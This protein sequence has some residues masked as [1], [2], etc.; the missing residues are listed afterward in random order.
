MKAIVLTLSLAIGVTLAP[1]LSLEGAVATAREYLLREG[2]EV[3]GYFGVTVISITPDPP[4]VKLLRA[5]VGVEE[6]RMGQQV[7]KKPTGWADVI[8]PG[9]EGHTYLIKLEELK[10]RIPNAE[11]YEKT[12]GLAQVTQRGQPKGLRITSL[13]HDSFLHASGL[14]QEDVVETINGNRIGDGA[15]A[16]ELLKTAAKGFNIQVGITRDRSKRTIIYYT[17]PKK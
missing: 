16:M 9:R 3:P 10:Q 6:L 17:L 13:P 15:S 8:R 14:R 1:G 2:D 12:L 4:T 7:E 5:G 11:K